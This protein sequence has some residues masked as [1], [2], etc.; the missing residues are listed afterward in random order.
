MK[1]QSLFVALAFL[2]VGANC[3]PAQGATVVSQDSRFR[4]GRL[5]NGLMYYIQENDLPVGQMHFALVQKPIRKPFYEEVLNTSDLVGV[6]DGIVALERTLKELLIMSPGTYRPHLTGVFLTGTF[7]ADSAEAFLQ[8]RLGTLPPTVE[9]MRAQ[10][11]PQGTDSAFITKSFL[12]KPLP[13]DLQKGYPQ[14]AI[15]FPLPPLPREMRAE[16][17]FFVMDFL[18]FVMKYAATQPLKHPI[19][20]RAE[21]HMVWE[22]HVHPDSLT[23]TFHTMSAE[24]LRLARNGVSQEVFDAARKQY[25]RDEWYRFEKS[26]VRTN[27]QFAREYV[28]HF[29]DGMPAAEAAWR[30]GFVSRMVPYVTL[31][32]VN[33]YVKGVLLASEPNFTFSP[34]MDAADSLV[35]PVKYLPSFLQE[36]RA[37]L[38]EELTGISFPFEEALLMELSEQILDIDLRLQL[39]SLERSRVVPVIDA[40]SLEQLYGTLKNIPQGPFT[41]SVK[42]DVLSEVRAGEIVHTALEAHR[43]VTVWEL[44]GG[45]HFYVRPDTLQPG[46]VCFMAKEKAP[47]VCVP[48][49]PQDIFHKSAGPLLWKQTTQGLL[50][51]GNTTTD[52]LQTFLQQAAVQ[53]ENILENPSYIQSMQQEREKYIQ[54]GRNLS[55]NILLDS[56]RAMLFENRLASCAS[57]PKGFDFICTGDIPIDSLEQWVQSFLGGMP[58]PVA[59]SLEDAPEEVGMRKGMY[60][61]TISFPNPAQESK[62]VQVYSGPCPYTLEQYVLLQVLEKLVQQGTDGAVYV[63]T[64]LE[65]YPRGHYILYTG[66]S[67]DA[68]D[69]AYNRHRLE[70]TLANLAAFGPTQ[71]SLEKAKHALLASYK[72]NMFNAAWHARMLVLY[73]CSNRDFVTGYENTLQQT[74]RAMVRDFVRQI[75]EFGNSATVVLSGATNESTGTSYVK[76]P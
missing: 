35:T 55:R 5:P 53:I 42:A 10:E 57:A 33:Q 32:H 28:R 34:A 72:E 74:D 26:K 48:F 56:L 20:V 69:L 49:V 8:R 52:S 63:Q 11:I 50:L 59:F 14:V 27:R 31:R 9:V 43:G 65:Y 70:Q 47:E 38:E 68:R 4:T 1:W 12:A 64:V 40:D 46:T 44:S 21:T 67:S 61:Q 62:A 45:S 17:E 54:A 37:R 29:F 16:S 36:E 66:F 76:N 51:F 15:A 41:P 22:A 3:C 30:Y 75:M 19:Q 7:Q 6:N 23:A 18:K 71:Q 24:C 58:A 73:S 25:L 13:P 60:E 39:D 2:I